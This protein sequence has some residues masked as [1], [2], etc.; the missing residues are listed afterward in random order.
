MDG[1]VFLKK[2]DITAIVN[3]LRIK[4][5]E[6]MK[7]FTMKAGKDKVSLKFPK[8]RC[9]FLTASG[10]SVYEARP[11]QCKTFPFWEENFVSPQSWREVQEYCKACRK[12]KYPFWKG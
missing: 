9:V 12:M 3:H 8:K 4:K 11:I 2:G 5:S 6:F 7:K 1:Y 10:C